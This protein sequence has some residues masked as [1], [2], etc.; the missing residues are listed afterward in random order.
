[1]KR[2]K[3]FNLKEFLIRNYQKLT[4]TQ[5]Y[6]F[7]LLVLFLVINTYLV[8]HVIAEKLGATGS[9]IAMINHC[10]IY[11]GLATVVLVALISQYDLKRIFALK[12]LV[13]YSVYLILS[14][15]V[16]VA[17]HIN[18]PKYKI[19]DFVK[20]GFWQ[21]NS[22]VFVSVLVASSLLFSTIRQWFDNKAVKRKTRP[23]GKLFEY[24]LH[25]SILT[26]F[27]LTDSKIPSTLY[28]TTWYLIDGIGKTGGGKYSLSQF[29]FVESRMI[30]FSILLTLIGLFFVKGQIDLVKNRSSFSL[31]I[32][33]SIS[34][35]DRKSVV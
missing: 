2:K 5:L 32:M 7:A 10:G 11:F 15:S 12:I 13:S 35:A 19:F 8:Q 9:V 24:L 27:V 3:K 6:S 29:W 23:I 20:N 26:T 16:E 28:R 22:I 1:M 4:R 21:T 33:T 30:G 14:Y 17:L 18:V 31:A 25:S 34:L